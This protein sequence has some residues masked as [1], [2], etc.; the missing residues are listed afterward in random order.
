MQIRIQQSPT[1]A[2]TWT[3]V[4]TKTVTGRQLT[5][6]FV[7]HRWK[8]ADYGTADPGGQYDVKVTNLSGEHD[9]ERNFGN[10]SW[11]ALRTIT[12][13][14]PVPVGGVAMLAVRILSSGQLQGVLDELRV[15]AQTLAR[16]YD[17]VSGHWVWRPT[18]QPAALCRHV[19]QHPARQ[20]PAADAAIDLA[21]LA[22]WDAITRAKGRS[23]Q[24]RG[25]GQ[26]L[27]V[28]GAGRHRPRRPGDAVP[29]RP[30]LL[31]RHRRAQD[32][33]GAA[34]QP[35]QF[36]GP[37]RARS[38]TGRCRTPTGSATSTPMRDWHADEVVVYDDGQSGRDRDPD[39]AGRVARH[40][41][42]RPGVERGPLSPGPA[43][44]RRE[45]HRIVVDF[46][47]LACERG[48]ESLP[49][50]VGLAA[51][52]MAAVS[53]PLGPLLRSMPPLRAYAIDIAGSMT[54]IAMFA[55]LSALGTTPAVWF[56]L[57]AILLA[58]LGLARGV[59]AWAA[60]TAACLLIIVGYSATLS[61]TW[62][63]YQRLTVYRP[64]TT[65]SGSTPT[66]CRTRASRWTPTGSRSPSTPSS[67]SGS[68]GRRTTAS[69]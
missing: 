26:G 39:R 46:E 55:G 33:A 2:E 49:L 69:W 4:A 67:T 17:A 45:I 12:T 18:S 15:V 57:L 43:R 61:D 14:S 63:P 22:D 42:P 3:T 6:L 13:Q 59:T 48:D 51:A 53:L 47:H 62:S 16:D 19:L 44:L 10:F 29:A 7:G 52:V 50:V 35:A 1:G 34:V 32:R 24:R 54:G 68:R 25:R 36:A 64:R 23:L 28:V 37:T 21:R 60:V 30:D 38:P 40:H 5:P 58:L 31:G 11:I 65:R 9:E 66:G 56:A 41:Q 27:A 20:R 8:P